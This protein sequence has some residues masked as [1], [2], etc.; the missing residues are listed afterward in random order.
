MSIVKKFALVAILSASLPLAAQAASNNPDTPSTAPA[1]VASK[2]SEPAGFASLD[3]NKDG[4]VTLAEYTHGAKGEV[5]KKEKAMFVS[6]D[7]N[8]DH[9]LT[10][11]EFGETVAN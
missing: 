9:K 1:K 7:K 10:P 2:M 11:A 8:K 3:K 4:K 5:A 6:L